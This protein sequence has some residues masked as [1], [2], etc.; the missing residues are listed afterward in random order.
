MAMSIYDYVR[1]AALIVIVIVLATQKAKTYILADAVITLTTGVG[2]I[3]G[4]S[5][6][7]Y[8][9]ETTLTYDGLHV[10]IN[11]T[12]ISFVLMPALFYLFFAR[13]AKDD[14]AAQGLL[15][16]RTLMIGLATF[17]IAFNQWRNPRIFKDTHVSVRLSSTVLWFCLA[18]YVLYRSGIAP[19]RRG[20]VSPINLYIKIDIVIAALYGLFDLLFA[21]F[22]GS[23]ISAR[24]DLL[25]EHLT[26]LEGAA[27][28]STAVLGVYALGFRN[29]AERK[30]YL[31]CRL[32]VL[33]LTS[34]CLACGL[35]NKKL[36]LT[37]VRHWSVCIRPHPGHSSGHW[38]CTDR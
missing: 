21:R 11:Q 10:L 18:A 2:S 13:S 6:L 32:T 4:F 26:T 7:T 27:N 1:L 23:L 37:G 8:E 28:L 33:L 5:Q 14:D 30:G 34:C 15:A 12:L 25:H 29:I 31:C 24:F 35:Y 36:T 19:P 9:S 3:W 22:A 20:R 38:P 16:T 17:I